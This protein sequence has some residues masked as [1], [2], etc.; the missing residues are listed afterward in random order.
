M[1]SVGAIIYDKDSNLLLQKRDNIES[2][3]FPGLWGLFGGAC[4]TDERL[5]DA[6]KREVEE[7]LGIIVTSSN[8]FLTLSIDSAIFGDTRKR[9]FYEVFFDKN[10]KERIV[11]REGESFKFFPYEQLPSIDQITSF[12]LAAISLFIYSKF[13]IRQIAPI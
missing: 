5:D 7:E 12:D 4:H 13:H 10:Q 11:L 2:I 6:I 8:L 3:Y 9:L 1:T